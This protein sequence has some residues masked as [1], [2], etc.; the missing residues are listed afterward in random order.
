MILS[1]FII[2][3]IYELINYLLIFL[4]FIILH[5]LIIIN[6]N[7]L[8]I[9]LIFTNIIQFL[10]INII[11]FKKLYL[12]PNIISTIQFINNIINYLLIFIIKSIYKIINYL[13]IFLIFIIKSI[14][15]IIN[16]K[17]KNKNKLPNKYYYKLVNCSTKKD[18]IELLSLLDDNSDNLTSG[19]YLKE[20]NNLKY[21]Y[22]KLN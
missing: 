21:L 16:Y 19:E 10:I 13:L 1:E 6:I 15:K 5:F 11:C 12:L 8:L 3:S 14:Y 9:F 18:I 22:D 20:S 7:Y 17:N 2:K 4:I